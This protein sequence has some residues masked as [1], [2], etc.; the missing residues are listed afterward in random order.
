METTLS[1]PLTQR[2]PQVAQLAAWAVILFISSLPAIVSNEILHI[3]APWLFWAQVGVLVVGMALSLF[4]Q[5]L[6]PLRLFFAVF[7]TLYLAQWGVSELAL[8]TQAPRIFVSSNPF[9]STMAFEQVQR[10]VVALVMLGTCWLLF[11]RRTAFFFAVGDLK[12]P[13]APIPFVGMTRPS[14]WRRLGP[15]LALCLAGGLATFV[16]IAGGAPLANLSGALPSLPFILLFAAMN[17]FSEEMNYRAPQL[18]ALT[19]A[20]GGPQALLMTAAYFGISH[21]YGVP[22]GVLG[23]LMAGLLGWLLGR[24]MLETKGMFWAWA[25]HFVMDVV[26]FTFMAAGSVTPGGG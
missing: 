22:Y 23:V 8:R 4:V 7:L 2:R 14:Q 12:A 18:G 20:V 26:I 24:S 1:N 13:A 10:F 21:F 15:I 25:I 17:A 9:A 3:Q 16:I 5:A 19:P 11:Q 6:R